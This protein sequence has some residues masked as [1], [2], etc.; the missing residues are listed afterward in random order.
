MELPSRVTSAL[1]VVLVTLFL[2]PAA[3]AH[4]AKLATGAPAPAFSLPSLNGTTSSDSLKG[5]V[6]YVDFW[7]SWCEPCRR[8]FAWMKTLQEKYGARGFTIVAVDLDKRREDADAFLDRYP[9]PFTVAFDPEGKVAEAFGVAAM[10]SSFLLDAN[11]KLMHAQ[12]GYDPK[13][14][15]TIETLIASACGQGATAGAKP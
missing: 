9:A 6:V 8:S 7:A 14:T 12:A 3:Q 13:K 1:A 10:P 15:A 11:G 2:S 4:S 5:K